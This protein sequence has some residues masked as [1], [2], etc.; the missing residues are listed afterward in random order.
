MLGTTC[1]G[2]NQLLTSLS[3]LDENYKDGGITDKNF[4]KSRVALMFEHLPISTQKDL[5]NLEQE[6]QEEEIPVKEY[7]KNLKKLIG[8]WPLP[9]END[10]KTKAVT[11]D[12]N[13]NGDCE[14]SNGNVQ[15]DADHPKAQIEEDCADHGPMEVEDCKEA[16]SAPVNAKK[17]RIQRGN[18]QSSDDRKGKDERSTNREAKDKDN[19][20][21]IEKRKTRSAVKSPSNQPSITSMF[22]RISNKRKSE[23]EGGEEKNENIEKRVKPVDAEII[24]E[25]EVKIPKNGEMQNSSTEPFLKP[26]TKSLP[27]KCKQCRQLLDDPDLNLFTGDPDDAVEEFVALTDERL[28][29]FTGN[30]E[31]ISEYDERPQHKLTEFSVYDK[32]THLCPFDSGLIEKNVELLFSGYIKPIYDESPAVEGGISTRNMGPINEWWTAGFDGGENALIG[33]STAFA[34]YI[35]MQPSEAYAP[36]IDAVK[37]KIHLSKCVIE[38]QVNNMDATYEDLLNKIQTTVPPAGK[39]SFTEDSLLRHSQFVIDQVQSY[40]DAAEEDESL[41]ITTPCMRS[42]IKLAGLTL[43]NRRVGRRGGIRKEAKKMAGPTKAQTT[44]LVTQVFELLFK[45][46]IDEGKA[47]KAPKRRRCG[48]CEIC[49]L[50]DC[51]KCTA[52]KDKTKFGG[53]GKLKQACDKR[54]CPNSAVMEAED[55]ELDLEMDNEDAMDKKAQTI[56]RTP[57]KK[58]C[59]QKQK[60]TLKWIGDERIE[61]RRKY[62]SSVKINEEEVAVGDCVLVSPDVPDNP[63]Y[64]AKVAYMWEDSNGTKHFHA[65]WYTRGGETVLGETADPNEVFMVDECEDTCLE[66]VVSKCNVIHKLPPKDWHMLGGEDVD[67]ENTWEEDGKNYFY[68]LWY[69]PEMAR[70]EDP[71]DATAPSNDPK[72]CICCARTD[73]VNQ[74]ESCQKGTQ[75]QEQPSDGR[76]SYSMVKRDGLEYMVGDCVF[77]IPEAFSFAVNPASQPKKKYKN[78]EAADDEELYPEYYRKGGYVKGSNSDIP[79][80]FRIG[81]IVEIYCPKKIFNGDDV[82]LKIQ[83]FYRPENTHKGVVAGY[84][85]DLNMVYWSNE[86]ATVDMKDVVTKCTV[87]NAE[88][89]TEPLAKYSR[90]RADRFYF[91]EAYNHDTKEFEEPPSE[92]WLMGAKGKGSKGKGKGK[93]KGKSS[94][95]PVEEEKSEE[96]KERELGFRKLRCLDVFAGC[97]GLSEGFH[98]AGIAES[99]WAIEVFEPAAQA[100]RINNP[101]CTVFTGDCNLL[102]KLAMEGEKTNGI[103]QRLPQKGDVELLCGGPPCQG[104]SGMNR[105]NSREYSMFKN[106]LI[107]S[108]LS[109]C[110][111]YRPKFFLLE[112]VRNFVSFK[113]NMVLKLALRCLVRMGYQCTF[114]VLQAGQ[115]GVPQTRRRAIILAAAPGEK[116]P[117]YPEPLHV[118]SPRACQLSVMVDDKKFSSNITWT[119]SAVYRTITVRDSMSD[120]PPI[121]NGAKNDEIA[122][123]GESQSHFQKMMRGNQYQP[124]LR[125]HICKEMNS[126]V[127]AR[128]RHIPLAPGSDW[129]DLPNVSVRLPDGTMTKKLRY[130]HSDKKNGKS[131]NG[132]LRGVCA[133]AEGKSCDPMDRQFGTIIPWCL[134]HTGNRHNHWAG[135]YGRLEW[136]GFF[137]TTVTNPEPMGKQG[138][139]LH[140]EQHRVVSV[141]ECARSQ[142]FPDTYRF[143]GNVLEKHRQVGNAVPPPMAAAI[144][145][146]VKKAVLERLKEEQ[147]K[148][149]CQKEGGDNNENEKEKED[150]LKKASVDCEKPIGDSQV[151]GT[152]A[153]VCGVMKTEGCTKSEESSEE[154]TNADVGASSS[155]H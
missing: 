24:E 47:A 102:L 120:L 18:N 71:P 32:N 51:G 118:F 107:A 48:V 139:V 80:P 45:G 131:D 60:T 94:A 128:M 12:M 11:E 109:Y 114:A 34:D 135:L 19:E 143:F 123:N 103:G 129:R 110:D 3:E 23:A 7:Y 88:N 6:L 29:L 151:I 92:A 153:E 137:S 39:T 89:L 125:D 100:F 2:S 101:G 106:S 31:T 142:G 83:K 26:E 113:R 95:P 59:H 121:K 55:N 117:F 44:P 70:F 85:A 17:R 16:S 61:G 77:L 63:L 145:R 13:G 136:D 155:S 73:E 96:E 21:G 76:T 108:Y 53:S 111:Y 28:S 140:P 127:A 9:D 42:L 144:G 20:G 90:N 134:P 67:A 66:F 87:V 99:R 75:L 43:G 81:R 50:P 138:R 133:C 10:Q 72:F 14:R 68:K 126:L 35:L 38:F 56:Q 40:D 122:Y 82:R 46:Q 30:E 1:E 91:R 148:E 49:Q 54:N 130:T 146:E 105:F 4:W 33:F 5:Q 104:F 93:G 62:Y 119:Q 25:K 132:E 79:E 22:S 150:V 97:G 64:I 84:Q 115:Y 98:Q 15:M 152:S 8:V 147:A 37:E 74:R 27:Q 52:C 58:K 149:K 65:Q 141:R 78:N 154:S 116:L 112:N 36:Y 69:D 86:I 124:I 57:T 41:L